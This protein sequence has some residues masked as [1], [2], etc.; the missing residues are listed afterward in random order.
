MSD[1]GWWSG[2]TGSGDGD[3]W[4]DSGSETGRGKG[5]RAW[6]K[7]RT[8]WTRLEPDTRD[9]E[10]NTM[11]AKVRDPAWM[12]TRQW[13]FGEFNGEDAGSPVV[14]DMS[15]EREYM[16][17]VRLGLDS[18]DTTI[19]Y[20]NRP[21]EALVEREPMTTASDTSPGLRTRVE[22]GQA[23][24]RALTEAG[25]TKSGSPYVADDF[26]DESTGDGREFIASEPDEPMDAEARRFASLSAGRALDGHAV[27]ERIVV[28]TQKTHQASDWKGVS[29]PSQQAEIE[30][31][32]IPQ[33]KSLSDPDAEDLK[34]GMKNFVDHYEGLFDEPSSSD[35]FPWR[36]DRLEY[37]FE[38]ATGNQN[39]ETVFEAPEYSGGHLDWYSFSVGDDT[40]SLD[41]PEA[42]SD[43]SRLAEQGSDEAVLSRAEYKGMPV[44]RFWEFE[45]GEVSLDSLPAGPD[46]LTKMLTTDFT[47]AYGNNWFVLPMDAPI[48]SLTHITEFTVTDNFGRQT[49]INPVT[50]ETGGPWNMY[51]HEDVTSSGTADRPGL[52]LPPTLDESVTS[53]PKE[54]VYFT[55]DQMANMAFA[56]EERVEGPTGDTRVRAE[57]DEPELTVDRIAT[58]KG[59]DEERVVLR[60]TGDA[61]LDVTG[62]VVLYSAISKQNLGSDP[63]LAELHTFPG[64][65]SDPFLVRPDETVTIYTAGKPPGEVPPDDE[66]YADVQSQQSP[67]S[68]SHVWSGNTAFGEVMVRRAQSYGTD[69]ERFVTK[70]LVRDP[71][72]AMPDY[73]LATSVPDYW[74]PLKPK[75]PK[76]GRNAARDQETAY[77]LALALLL[78]ADSMDDP[79]PR[80]PTP[81]GRLLSGSDNFELYE[82]EVPR[83]GREVERY[84]QLARWT[85]GST[86]VWSSREASNGKGEARS[87]LRYDLLDAPDAESASE[88]S[89]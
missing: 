68:S 62:W 79:L 30:K 22:A 18:D 6:T 10:F 46:E 37:G 50:H 55:R 60:N 39:T 9:P 42:D 23:F 29:W 80:I 34:E 3:V 53:E 56:V 41:A 83:S 70:E 89:E 71:D 73:R 25:Y 54:R 38:V 32:P 52:F 40:D 1:H 11:G 33:G 27:Y 28:Q 19:D 59:V 8:F 63:S 72:E 44:S 15:Y 17:R 76:T 36:E 12:L 66:V 85:D 61:P 21:L 84:A 47:F 26:V 35:S 5:Y 74:F 2:K 67:Q 49:T 87:R 13:Q 82:E 43:G 48:G 24:L 65:D 16:S 78:D 69:N 51:M 57:F 77:Q 75:E 31:L 64:S 7:S 86:W 45:D 81:Q 20:Q 4:R 14:A 58:G 88:K